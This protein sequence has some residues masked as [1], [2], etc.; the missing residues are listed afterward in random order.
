MNS[1]LRC[2]TGGAILAVALIFGRD[3][4]G[5]VDDSAIRFVDVTDSSGLLFKHQDG[6][7]GNRYLVELMGAGVCSF[8]ADGDGLVDVFMLNG[9]EL[10]R[11]GK[12]KPDDRQSCQLFRNRGSFKFADCTMQ[13]GVWVEGYALGITAGDFNHD[14]FNDLYV[15]TYGFNVLL[16]NNG[17]G[18]F[19]DVAKEAGVQGEGEFGAGVTFLD[20]NNDGNLDLFVGNYVEFDFDRHFELAPKAFPYS[21]GPKDYPPSRDRLFLNRGDGSFDD[22]SKSSGI[23]DSA[24]PSMGVVAADFDDDGDIDIFVACDG[25]ANLLYQNDGTG[26]FT[27]EAIF[28]GV[29]FD[30][31]GNANGGM[32]VDAADINGDGLID[33]FVTDYSDQFPELFLNG[34]PAGVFEDAARRLQVGLEVYLHVNWGIG[35]IDFDLDGDVDA[36][37]CNGHLLENAKE[38]E[39]NTSYGVANTILENEKGRLFRTVTKQAGEAL[40]LAESSRGAA[41]DDFD[42]D[43]DIDAVV[44]NCDSMNQVLENQQTR[45]NNWIGFRLIGT[46]ANRSAVGAKVVVRSGGKDKTLWKLNGRGY[47]S[48]YGERLHT[49]LGPS[50]DRTDEQRGNVVDEVIVYWPGNPEPTIV[51]GLA[52]N[53]FHEIV[54]PHSR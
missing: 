12:R 8:D 47:Q 11:G 50:A 26:K 27:E 34:Q 40:G 48:F 9:Y 45:S 15:S 22:V 41:F 39:P 17:D 6:S 44:L 4:C 32:G 1:V 36:F 21:P 52:V 10:S 42:N 2:I 3:A 16:V 38:I 46:K 33:L 43:G 53:K 31:R 25:A 24:G 7:D 18:T 5:Q 19:A 13:S 29:A 14:G 28:V 37:V 30:M 20:V 23:A 54:E 51:K 49:G 35:L